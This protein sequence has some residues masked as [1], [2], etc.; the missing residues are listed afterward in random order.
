MRYPISK[1]FTVI[2]LI[3]VM[4]VIGILAVLIIPRVLS[5]GTINAQEAAQLVAAD[6]RKTKDLA[7]ADTASHGITFS[8]GSA[9]Y[10]IDQGT[11][12][13]QTVSLPSGVTIN[14]STTI[15]FSTSG[16]PTGTPALVVNVGGVTTVTVVQNTGRV[17]VP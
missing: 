17:T 9:T 3:V 1:G 10:T 2:E 14:T 5:T 11:A 13:A 4:A 6:I 16:V 7:L 8:S 15:T 12:N